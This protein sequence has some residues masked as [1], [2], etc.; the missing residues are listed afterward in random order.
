[1]LMYD[2]DKDNNSY[3]IL[4]KR[5]A[6]AKSTQ[7]ERRMTERMKGFR[8]EMLK[9]MNMSG[10]HAKIFGGVMGEKSERGNSKREGE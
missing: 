10:R 5:V 8:K 1:M 6:V 9:A 3:K 7:K 2:T 4:D